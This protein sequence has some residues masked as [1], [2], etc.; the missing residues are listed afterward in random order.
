MKGTATLKI[1]AQGHWYDPKTGEPKH[2]VEKKDGSGLRPTTLRD[3]RANGWVP[4]VTTI[5]R[6]L[7]KPALTQWL[8]RQAVLTVLTAPRPSDEPLDA[9]VDRVLSQERQQD[10]EAA[11]A[12]D[13]GSEIHDNLEKA[14]TGG[15]VASKI[16]PWIEPCLKAITARGKVLFTEKILVGDGYAGKT[17]LI[18]NDYRCTWLLDYKSTTKLPEKSSWQEHRLQLAAYAQAYDVS[19]PPHLYPVKTANVYISTKECGKF[20]IHEN[21]AWAADYECF[22]HLVKVWQHLNAYCV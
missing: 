6:V 16:E 10:Q 8:I 4:S 17:D 13:L 1:E 19:S 12:R 21:P 5:L 11:A 3:A 15:S 2:F 20:I 9:F 18:Q 7:E 22:E 14:L